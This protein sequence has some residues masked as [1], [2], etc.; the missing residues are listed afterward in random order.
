[1]YIYKI[2]NIVNNKIYIGQTRNVDDRWYKHNYN[3]LSG[4]KGHLYDAMRKYG[5][6]NFTIEVIEECDDDIVDDREKYWIAHY[7][8]TDNVVIIKQLVDKMHQHGIFL[9]TEMLH[10][11]VLVIV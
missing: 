5:L 4:R 11:N 8:S 6:E 9:M 10:Q 3:A 2:T 1:M 7:N